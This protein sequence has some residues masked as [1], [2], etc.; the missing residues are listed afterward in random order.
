VWE[1]TA[2]A[3]KGEPRLVQTIQLPFGGFFPPNA[4]FA[5]S[6]DG[7]LL[8]YASGGVPSHV[9]VHQVSSGKEVSRWTL[10]GGF[11]SLASTGAGKFLLVREQ[12]TRPKR[13]VDTVVWELEAG[14]AAKQVTVLRKSQPGDQ[15]TFL[16][17]RLTPDGRFYLWL[18]PR[19][20]GNP[21]V[22][23]WDVKTGKQVKAMSGGTKG[24]E[25]SW[26]SRDGR[27]L[28]V[29][30]Q[31]QW[32]L[33]DLEQGGPPVR[34]PEGPPADMGKGNDLLRHERGGWLEEDRLVW[35]RK[36]RRFLNLPAGAVDFS[37]SPD[38]RTAAWGPTR[39]RSGSRTFRSWRRRWRGSSSRCH[40]NDHGRAPRAGQRNK[41]SEEET[42]IAV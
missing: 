29:G 42:S 35:W 20:G 4:G 6:A 7:Q 13:T 40:G 23:V 5:L 2:G 14:K 3:G 26:L 36:D 27:R 37:F 30:R 9:R 8:A 24:E 1:R 16:S 25:G 21:R 38:G 28:W 39:G 15:L 12:L 10:P 34:D 18:G 19:E 17:R 22:E 11:E 41:E 32:W 31:R 33:H